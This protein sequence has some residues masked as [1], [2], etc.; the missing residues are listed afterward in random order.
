MCFF[1]MT[2]DCFMHI[3][4]TTTVFAFPLFVLSP[5]KRFNTISLKGIQV[6]YQ[7]HFVPGPI[8]PV[9]FA[10]Q[11][12]WKVRTLAAVFKSFRSQGVTVFNFALHSCFGVPCVDS[13]APIAPVL[14]SQECHADAAVHSTRG[15]ET[16]FFIHQITSR[17][18]LNVCPDTW[19]DRYRWIH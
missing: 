8:S 13:P 19:W 7:A 18:Q 5:S 14:F 16:H 6:F 1:T 10:D 4:D 11:N 17:K 12:T 3:D 15:D 2:T 9:H